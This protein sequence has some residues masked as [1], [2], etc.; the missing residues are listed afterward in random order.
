MHCIPGCGWRTIQDNLSYLGFVTAACCTLEVHVRG[1]EKHSV[2]DSEVTLSPSSLVLFSKNSGREKF[3]DDK[4]GL[5][6]S[7]T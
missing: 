4:K 7:L 1:Y 3:C 2:P 5:C 6:R